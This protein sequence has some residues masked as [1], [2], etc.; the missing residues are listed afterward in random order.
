MKGLRD[1]LNERERSVLELIVEN[2]IVFA[3][4]VGSTTIAKI[5]KK[6]VSS[7]TIRSIMSELEE[8]GFLFKPHAV[9]GRV[10][11]P[12]AFRYYVNSLPVPG[13][14][15]KKELKALETMSRIRYAYT[16]EVMADAS[17]DAC[18]HCGDSEHCRG[19]Q[20]RYHAF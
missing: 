5:M 9:A 16:E 13:L 4:P 20:G 8:L 15:G 12:K 1:I 7:A 18:G 6:K 3:E 10:P 19:T 11:T 17:R 2:Y 14:P